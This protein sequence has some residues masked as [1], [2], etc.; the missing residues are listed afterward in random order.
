MGPI[1]IV[2]LV[3]L[4]GWNSVKGYWERLGPST[5][6]QDEPVDEI[7]K[8]DK[9]DGRKS[10]CCS[11]LLVWNS[12][13]DYW[14][15]LYGSVVYSIT[16]LLIGMLLSIASPKSV[17]AQGR[18][19]TFVVGGLCSVFILIMNEGF[20]RLKFLTGHF[21]DTEP[22]NIF[23][24]FTRKFERLSVWFLWFCVNLIPKRTDF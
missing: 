17:R 16:K 18:T 2:V 19:F 14:E 13:K 22:F 20:D 21:V 6:T 7:M 4:L 15:R 23:T 3:C 5:V 10:H 12:V 8:P 24:L 11:W 9:S 1:H